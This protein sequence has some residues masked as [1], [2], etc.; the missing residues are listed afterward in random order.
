VLEQLILGECEKH[1][2]SADVRGVFVALKGN[3]LVEQIVD[4]KLNQ[5]QNTGNELLYDLIL[6]AYAYNRKR[7]VPEFVY[8]VNERIYDTS[9][10]RICL[11]LHSYFSPLSAILLK[12]RCPFVI[13]SDFPK[14]IIET[15]LSSGI[16]SGKM[17]FIS[18]DETCLLNAKKFLKRNYAVSSTIDFQRTPTS[19]FSL[20]SD[21]ML[22]LALY[23]RPASFFGINYVSDAGELNYVTRDIDLDC[24]IDQI[25]RDLVAFIAN[26]KK[27]AKYTFSKFNY[28]EQRQPA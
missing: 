14:A 11:S 12:K 21:G 24:P 4:T 17:E 23:L 8:E 15:A 7:F 1:R 26:R 28:L 9:Q 22:R 10:P 13:V 18:R 19:A 3:P 16:T 27:A 20:L 6:A 25:K 2:F 5:Y